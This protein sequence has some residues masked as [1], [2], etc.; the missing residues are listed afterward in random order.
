LVRRECNIKVNHKERQYKDVAV[1]AL[2]GDSDGTPGAL[3]NGYPARSYCVKDLHVERICHE[4]GDTC[5]CG[6]HT[7]GYIPALQ[8]TEA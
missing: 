7:V 2:D 4:V 6:F 8:V 1:A 3:I 5:A